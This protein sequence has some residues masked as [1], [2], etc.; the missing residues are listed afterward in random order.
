MKKIFYL[1]LSLVIIPVLLSGCTRKQSVTNANQNSP[2]KNGD[3]V[4][5]PENSKLEWFAKTKIMPD[6]HHGLVSIKSGNVKITDASLEG[7]FKIDMTTITDLELTYSDQMKTNLENHLKS[8]DFF[9]AIKYPESVFTITKTEKLENNKYKITGNLT[10]KDITKE[11]SFETNFI[12]SKKDAIEVQAEFNIDR[13]NWGINYNSGK[14]ISTL[15][16]KA[17]DDDIKFKLDL[18]FAK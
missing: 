9:N 16:D 2:I 5:V 6:Y 11:L 8:Q 14:F 7:A 13:T 10:I 1:L 18:N 3:Y 12:Q 17:I 15:G 4:L